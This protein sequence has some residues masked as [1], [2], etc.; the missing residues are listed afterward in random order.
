VPF[1]AG[2][3]IVGRLYLTSLR[4]RAFE[5]ADVDF[6]LDVL[7]HTIPVLD[8]IQLVDRLASDAAKTERQRIARNLHD[9]V[10]QPCVG[11]RLGLAAI[12]R[13]FLLAGTEAG[14]ELER[15]V[16][17]S[18]VALADLRHCIG[19]LRGSV[20]QDG[21]LPV[22]CQFG[23]RFAKA[24][25]IAVHV[26]A[27]GNLDLNNRLTAEVLQMMAEGLSNVQRHTHST[28]ATVGLA[29][30][31]G[32]LTVRIENDAGDKLPAPFTPRSIAERAVALGGH[33]RVEQTG[34]GSTIVLVDIPL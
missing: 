21:L 22:L 32:H 3:E 24:T 5:D 18:D 9:G 26:E 34:T 12:K 31:E 30:H 10:V 13:K 4:R 20:L 14:E 8:T 7:D 28:W 16:Q 15:L 11:L 6:L 1:H 33:T 23:Q 27:E 29:R 2:G 17:L 19:E 25:G